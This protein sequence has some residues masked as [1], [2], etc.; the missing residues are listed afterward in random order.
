MACGDIKCK[1]EGTNDAKSSLLNSL[2]KAQRQFPSDMPGI[3][4]VKVPQRWVDLN[5]GNLGLETEVSDASAKLRAPAS[6]LIKTSP[7]PHELSM[8]ISRREISPDV[9]SL[10][11]AFLRRS[12]G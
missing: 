7:S 6:C 2:K 5:T 12:A 10:H 8:E 3:V 9:K 11:R 4:F 1:L